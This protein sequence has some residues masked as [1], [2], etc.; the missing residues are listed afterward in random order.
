MMGATLFRVK[1]A[2]GVGGVAAVPARCWGRAPAGGWPWVRS[3]TAPLNTRDG[4]GELRQALTEIREALRVRG[5]ALD[6]AL[7][8]PL[9]EARR[10]ELPRMSRL[11]LRR[12]L[13][14]DA[15]AHFPA[16]RGEQ[17][18]AAEPLSAS[19]R[20]SPR[21]VL[22]AIASADL[23]EAVR[24]AARDAGWR[25]DGV[26][27]AQAAWAAAAP[28]LAGA[29]AGWRPGRLLVAHATGVE[30]L[31][32][33]RGELVGARRLR[34]SEPSAVVAAA[35]AG[36]GRSREP[37][38]LAVCG[39]EDAS[40][41]LRQALGTAEAPVRGRARASAAGLHGSAAVLAARFADRA[42]AF[43]LRSAADDAAALR[44]AGRRTIALAAAA[45][46]LVALA[47]ALELLGAHRELA[48]VRAARAV[49]RPVV[50][51]ALV[52]RAAADR[53]EGRLS[54]VSALQSSAVPWA[55]VLAEVTDALPADAYLTRFQ[56][57][58][59]S[60]RV[61]AVGARAAS[62]LEALQDAPGLRG[63]GVVGTIR[64]D[65]GTIPGAPALERFVIS[66]RAAA[67]SEAEERP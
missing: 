19:R 2:L 50:E 15:G 49:D 66:G 61:E 45:A 58:G 57:E 24:R 25:V 36:W 62:A 47:G 26:V 14:R 28:R 38:W 65:A 44:G 4:I 17:L 1:L 18:A 42:P 21:P 13:A 67:S 30:L 33:D 48:V 8:P 20:R 11:E 63:V 9:A 6:V 7:L 53:V 35:R 22:A 41:A 52:A 34:V 64:R 51:R 3:F 37:R 40:E 59:D 27:P 56:G 60:I 5:G 32:L 29:A 16:V 43:R 54:A 31:A 12:V 39:A 55:S 10:V 23:V 46:A